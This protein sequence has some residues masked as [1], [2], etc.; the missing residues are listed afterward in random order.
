MLATNGWFNTNYYAEE[1]IA[2]A[3]FMILPEP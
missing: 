3:T 1:A 2:K